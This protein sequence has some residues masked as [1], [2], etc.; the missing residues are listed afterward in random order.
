MK[1]KKFLFVITTMFL[2]VQGASAWN[3]SGSS[4][5]PYLI[6]STADWN[7]LASNVANG[8][9]YSNTYFKLTADI[10]VTTMVT[11]T[12]SGTFDGGGH[13]LTFNYTATGNN[14]APFAYITGAPQVL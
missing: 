14:A 2:M 13:T 4:G 11:A 9:T 7:T 6:A 12:F 8:N 5:D 1:I 3:G 10:T